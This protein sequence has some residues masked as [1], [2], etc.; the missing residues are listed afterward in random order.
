MPLGL[1]F[2]GFGHCQSQ[3]SMSQGLFGN[4]F[5]LRKE[6]ESLPREV[7][8]PEG[9]AETPLDPSQLVQRPGLFSE[10]PDPAEDSQRSA[11]LIAPFL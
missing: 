9:I 11:E 3:L 8:R 10:E 5:H 1:G 4:G 2:V 7:G 6:L